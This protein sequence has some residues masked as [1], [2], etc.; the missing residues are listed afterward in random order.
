MPARAELYLF[1]T[2]FRPVCG[3]VHRDERNIPRTEHFNAIQRCFY[4]STADQLIY[5]SIYLSVFGG[6]GVRECD[7]VGV[8]TFSS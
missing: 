7:Y 2:S 4:N 3:D 1:N 8:S 5:L 6:I